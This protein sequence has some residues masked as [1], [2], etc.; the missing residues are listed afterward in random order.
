MTTR[1]RVPVMAALL[2]VAVALPACTPSLARHSVRPTEVSTPTPTPT[3]T[4]TSTTVAELNAAIA[5][6]HRTPATITYRTERQR[7]GMPESVHQCLR[8]F[9][10]ERTGVQ[11]AL[12]KCDPNGVVTLAWDPPGR[13]RLDVVEGGTTFTAIVVGRDGVVCE[14][15]G[16]GKASCRSRTVDAI[17]RDLPFRELIAEANS[18]ASAVGLPP[19]G[20][21]TM[22]TDVVAGLPARCFERRSGA[23]AARW[24]FSDEGALLSLE[25]TEEGRAPTKVEASR[26]SGGVDPKAFDPP[27]DTA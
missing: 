6:W 19:A 3:P 21:V 7:P 12:T 4:P 1:R 14:R 25:L 27:A 9:V 10:T 20:P 8:A 22:T 5:R 11:A 23:S 2:V 17:L 15:P 13:W 16:R 26:V 24:C 18:T